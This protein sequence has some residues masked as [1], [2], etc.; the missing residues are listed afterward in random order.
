[1]EN[2]IYLVVEGQPLASCYIS[3]KSLEEALFLFYG[4]FG[5]QDLYVYRN[6][7]PL[8]KGY[9]M[10]CPILYI[11]KNKFK[12]IINKYIVAEQLEIPLDTFH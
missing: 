2:L 12:K 3:D 5:Y 6:S 7:S 10:L 1:M 9:S 11:S 8:S 4:V